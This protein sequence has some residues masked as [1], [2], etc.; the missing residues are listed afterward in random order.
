MDACQRGVVLLLCQLAAL[1]LLGEELRRVG[2][3]LVGSLLAHILQH[4]LYAAAG[5]DVGDARAHHAGAENTD[6]GEARLGHAGRA[7]HAGLDVV[8]L[9]PEG[10]DHVAGHRAARQLDEVARLDAQRRVHIHLRAFHSRAQDGLGRGHHALGFFAEHRG[11]D[12]QL[13]RQRRVRGCAA[14]HFVAR[15]VPGLLRLRVRGDPGA[16]LLEHVFLGAREFMHQA[17]LKAFLGVE[18]LTFHQERQRGLQ[19]QQPHHPHHAAAAGQ[20]A[21]RHLGQAER[22]LGVVQRNAV[23]RAQADL[24][25]TAERGA[26]DGSH[27]RL[28]QRFQLAHLL[29]QRLREVPHELRGLLLRLHHFFQVRACKERGLGRAQDHARQIGLG[30][31]LRHHGGEVLAEGD[32]H[33]VRRFRGVVEDHVD[34]VGRVLFVANAFHVCCFPVL[35]FF[36]GAR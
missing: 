25:A 32:I 18:L 3:A 24:P 23:V 31:E 5:T 2:L 34:D 20:Q 30:L 13:R 15:H 22:G 6:L 33:Q 8:Q 35:R 7:S 10:I 1:E 28:A 26:V 11:H 16:R 9:E 14:G 21:Q 19:A 27:H 29:L 36:R 12:H 4:H 17:E